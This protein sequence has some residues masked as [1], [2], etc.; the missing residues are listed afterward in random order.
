MRKT[1]VAYFKVPDLHM[2]AEILKCF[3]LG[4]TAPSGP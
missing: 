4:S 3:T 1:T 2:P